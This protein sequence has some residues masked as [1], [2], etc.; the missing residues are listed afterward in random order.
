MIP[1]ENHANLG[2]FVYPHKVVQFH[3]INTLEYMQT[4]IHIIVDVNIGDLTKIEA[5]AKN[6]RGIERRRSPRTD[7][8]TATRRHQRRFN[9]VDLGLQP[10]PLPIP[11]TAASVPGHKASKKVSNCFIT[12]YICY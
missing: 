9:I 3:K 5:S 1:L 11:P 2:N 7:Q 6:M 12:Y 10:P 4:V 8:D